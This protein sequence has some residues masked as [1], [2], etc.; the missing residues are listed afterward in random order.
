MTAKDIRKY[1]LINKI[2]SSAPNNAEIVSWFSELAQ[3]DFQVAFEVWEYILGI[4]SKEVADKDTSINLEAKIFG[5]FYHDVSET[6]TR[7]LFSASEPIIKLV[8]GACRTSCVGPNARM[9]AGFILSGKL[10]TAA[11]A[12]AAARQNPTGDFGERMREIVDKVFSIYCESKGVV[13]CELTR[14]QSA[15]LLEYVGKIKGPN[16]MLLTQRIKEL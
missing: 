15:L 3:I 10:E 9:L 16:K 12:L 7:Q 1:T 2:M 6:K 13:K 11:L 14:K 5:T 8:Y 4:Y